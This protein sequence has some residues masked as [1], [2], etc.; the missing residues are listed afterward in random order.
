MFTEKTKKRQIMSKNTV[1]F[2]FE[3]IEP[4]TYTSE[5]QRVLVFRN[6]MYLLLYSFM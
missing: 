6:F 1:L 2:S 5:N 3:V 4:N